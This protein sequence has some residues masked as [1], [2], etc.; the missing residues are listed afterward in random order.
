MCRRSLDTEG[1]ENVVLG[2]GD[3][4]Q[5]MDYVYDR[6]PKYYLDG[7]KWVYELIE[8][9]NWKEQGF[10]P[11]EGTWQEQPNFLIEG[12]GFMDFLSQQKQVKAH[13]ASMAK[14]KASKGKNGRK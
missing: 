1:D 7:Q 14:I 5:I 6:R 12:F 13:E 4:F 10:L 8:A 11:N 3:S 2:A 9:W